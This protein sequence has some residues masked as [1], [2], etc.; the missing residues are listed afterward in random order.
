MRLRGQRDCI[1]EPV[2]CAVSTYTG[3]H[4][5][6]LR[7]GAIQVFEE[8]SAEAQPRTLCE[9]GSPVLELRFG[10]EGDGLAS[11][12]ENREV[13]LWNLERGSVADS[14]FVGDPIESIDVD[15]SGLIFAAIPAWYS[16]ARYHEGAI[17]RPSVIHSRPTTTVRVGDNWIFS[18]AQDGV[19]KA[20]NRGLGEVAS[21]TS[22][23]K[24]IDLLEVDATG[25]FLVLAHA[26]GVVASW[27]FRQPPERRYLSSSHGLVFLDG[28]RAFDSR[29]LCEFES[30]LEQEI[31]LLPERGTSAVVPLG[32]EGAFLCGE[33][34]GLLTLIAA[35]D[36]VVLSRP[37]HRAAVRALAVDPSGE[38][39][40]SVA[41]DGEAKLWRLPDLEELHRI[42]L[43]P[44]ATMRA[45]WNSAGDRVLFSGHGEVSLLE[46]GGEAPLL[47]EFSWRGPA[48]FVGELVAVAGEVGEVV[49]RDLEDGS[50]RATC[51]GQRF[52]LT[53]LLWHAPSE[54][55]LAAFESGRVLSWRGPEWQLSTIW[56]GCETGPTWMA[57]D[58]SGR[59]LAAG[60]ETGVTPKLFGFE[61]GRPLAQVLRDG[62]VAGCFA[63]GLDELLL[64][65]QAGGVLAVDLAGLPVSTGEEP[66]ESSTPDG[67]AP[68]YEGVRTRLVG[69]HVTAVWGVAASPD[70]HR[71][72]TCSHDGVVKLWDFAREPQLLWS[73]DGHRDVAWSVA[74]DAQGERLVSTS[75]DVK[76][77]SARTSELLAEFPGH[78]LL[79][80][81]AGFSHTRPWLVTGSLDGTLRVWDLEAG[82][83]HLELWEIDAPIHALAF[84]P[85]GRWLAVAAHD[86]RV[87]LWDRLEEGDP[88]RAPD[89]ILDVGPS[90]P[91]ALTFDAQST[92]LAVAGEQGLISLWDTSTWD[93]SVRLRCDSDLL[94][95]VSFSADGELIAAGA[96]GTSAIIW[97]LVGVR[98][99][100]RDLDLDW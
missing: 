98:S 85:S 33:D 89:R 94:R 91:W 58:E 6:A 87:L 40:I 32:L 35:D 82:A 96:F 72:A 60:G 18:G 70:G 48:E 5:L 2:A 7:G 17:T 77:W 24:S 44:G 92:V 99:A 53:A 95:S 15:R 63:P 22:I 78:E 100:L 10:D 46:L 9:L 16:F 81:C 57:V 30:T 51:E 47:R 45:R 36:A 26:D 37:A 31:H 12:H 64:A 11:L 49:L 73:R 56:R 39:L 76:V 42:E 23:A 20:W 43:A 74:F 93:C 68:R 29:R 67:I 59:Y 8:W 54:S 65:S 27:E 66:S 50:I 38:R 19:L 75:L 3:H 41:A 86:G 88:Q 79:T 25:H 69:A 61:S 28:R 90:P 34:D 21:A 71:A 80:T 55:L 84:D 97:D 1:T 52:E 13:Q 14:L 62:I 83:L 4:A